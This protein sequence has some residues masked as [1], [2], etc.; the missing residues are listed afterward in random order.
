[1]VHISGWNFQE[2]FSFF[3]EWHPLDL[4]YRFLSSKIV[5]KSVGIEPVQNMLVQLTES[6]RGGWPRSVRKQTLRL[7]QRGDG[8]GQGHS[9]D[10]STEKR[11]RMVWDTEELEA[12]PRRCAVLGEVRL[13]GNGRTWQ[14]ISY[15]FVVQP[16]AWLNIY[17]TAGLVLTPTTLVF[18]VMWV[19]VENNTLLQLLG[20]A[21]A[22]EAKSAWWTWKHRENACKEKYLE[23]YAEKVLL[24]QLW[25]IGFYLYICIIN[26][27]AVL[28]VGSSG[29]EVW[30]GW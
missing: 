24:R 9:R 7:S 3:G 18:P 10:L 16:L 6:H 19:R 13:G 15:H 25:R 14:P 4:S 26:L 27:A 20:A 21:P 23:L 11:M 17:Q 28:C 12:G 30:K 2:I 8:V 5:W 29:M 1:M 22:Q